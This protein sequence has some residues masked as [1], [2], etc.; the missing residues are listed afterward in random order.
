MNGGEALLRE[1]ASGL[2]GECPWPDV[3]LGLAVPAPLLGAAVRMLPDWVR[4]GAQNV[5][6]EEA[7]AFTGEI[8]PAL[9]REVGCRFAIAGHSERRALFGEDDAAAVRRLSGALRSGL[10]GI[11]CVGESRREREA[12]RAEDVVERQLRGLADAGE[13]LDL[14]TGAEALI[15]YEPVWAIGS[16]E[17]ARPDQIAAMHEH[18]GRLSL[19]FFGTVLPVLYGGSVSGDNAAEIFALNS[20]AGALVGSASL[21]V[22]GL[23]N[24]AS[25]ASRIA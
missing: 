7:G 22:R 16:G 12:G 6:W 21:D 2:P 8:S 14:E 24:I 3:R 25:E 1:F 4:V 11:L 10:T 5:H 18:I 19:R 13:P 15:A 9:L 23:I 17:A 20:A